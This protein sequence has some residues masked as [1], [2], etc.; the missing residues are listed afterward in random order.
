MGKITNIVN[1]IYADFIMPSRLNEYETL[2]KKSLEKNY[3]HLSV[4]EYYEK[5]LRNLL[6]PNKKYF[7][8]RHDIDTDI[9]T[10][11]KFFD[12][13]QKYNIKASYY[14]RLSTLDFKLMKEIDAYG[15]EASYHFEEIAQFCKDNHI[16]NTNGVYENLDKI[17]EN[18]SNNFFFIEKNLGYKIQSVASHGDFINRKLKIINNEITNDMRLRYKLGIILE[19][20]DDEFKSSFDIYISDKEHPIYYSPINI[21]DAIGK[22]EYKKIYMLTHPRQWQTNFK[23]NFCDNIKRIYEGLTW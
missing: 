11:R 22:E 10:A 9:K 8:H 7:V 5:L 23:V 3:I 2:I 1:R 14:F 16:K 15:S 12:T 21:F 20:Y 4:I 6:D 19:T 18:F 17:K 13:E